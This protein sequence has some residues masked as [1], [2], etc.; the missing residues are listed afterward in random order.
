MRSLSFTF[1]SLALLK[2]HPLSSATSISVISIT[3]DAR[4]DAIAIAMKVLAHTRIFS[5][6]TIR[7]EFNG[8][9]SHGLRNFSGMSIRAPLPGEPAFD[10]TGFPMLE[11]VELAFQQ[12]SRVNNARALVD[13]FID[14]ERRGVTV[15]LLPKGIA[16]EDV[17]ANAL[18]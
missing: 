6:R 8:Y 9:W 12:V 2:A 7:I 4:H 18:N 14:A 16:S 10:A 13:R 11:R 17:D 15:A 1:P 5:L 3:L